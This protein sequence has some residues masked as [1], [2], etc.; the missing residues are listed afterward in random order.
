VI[1]SATIPL[2]PAYVSPRNNVE[3]WEG[4]ISPRRTSR[5]SF[6]IFIPFTYKPLRSAML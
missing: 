1:F 2:R 4:R 6:S 3:F 5:Q